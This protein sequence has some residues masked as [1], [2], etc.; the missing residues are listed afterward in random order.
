MEEKN[1]V[2][3]RQLE[4]IYQIDFYR[5][6]FD[7]AGIRPFDIRR[8]DDF[9]K[10]P[11]TKSPEILEELRKRPSE[12]SLYSGDV[13]RINFSP[14]GQELYPVYQTH[15]DL[16]KMHEVCARSLEAAGVTK[17]DICVVTFGYHLFMAGLF[18]QSQ[19][20]SYGAKVI[21]LG[22]G[23][24]E[25]AINLINQYE[26][27]VLVTNP[28]FAMKLAAGGIPNVRIL[29]V[30][31]EPFTSVE[32]FPEKVRAAF[33]RDL[34]IIDSYSMA[35]CMPIAR[36]CQYDKGLHIMDDFIFAEV[37]DPLTGEAVLMGEKGELVLT[38]LYKE[39]VPLL[40]YRTGDLTFME[41]GKCQCGREITLPKGILG[42]TDE[43]L[44]IKGVKFWPSQVGLVLREFPEYSDRYRVLVRSEKG[45]D[46]LELQIEGKRCKEEDTEVLTRR[47][48]QET[49]LAFDRIEVLEHLGEGPRV[50]DERAGRVF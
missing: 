16:N 10:I 41:K 24:S 8:M 32:G 3:A 47:L 14:S 17:K 48:K 37:I 12:C 27:T 22:P 13:T 29:F 50:V 39:A 45:V 6:K 34:T 33:G 7:Q 49:L 5:Q 44:K 25:R 20:E 4:K 28:T 11:F 2:L 19:L 15:H 31:G 40:R 30:G 43:M 38:H 23:E 42:R 26:V 18:Y 46:K 9:K 35:L 1:E 36:S 21:P